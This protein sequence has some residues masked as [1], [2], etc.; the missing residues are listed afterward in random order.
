MTTDDQH[1]A[2][3]SVLMETVPLARSAF[4]NQLLS[5]FIAAGQR[6]RHRKPTTGMRRLIAPSLALIFVIAILIATPWGRSFAQQIMHFFSQAESDVVT[7]P[8]VIPPDE[9]QSYSTIRDAESAVGFNARTPATLPAGYV[10]DS[11]QANR[12][13]QVLRISY[14]GP[15]NQTGVM[16]PV[17]T[18][19]QRKLPF[20]DLIGPSAAIRELTISGGSAEYVEGGWMYVESSDDSQEKLFHWEE[21]FV[22]AQT[23]RWMSDGFYYGISF[24]GSDTQPGYLAMEDLIEMAEDLR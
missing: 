10:L 16:T 11:V 14:R 18:L 4:K 20:D 21:T 1:L 19:T 12:V 15:A 17:M 8:T 2:V 22:P 7:E 24:V 3:Y 9:L 13:E 5:K 23:L 6:P